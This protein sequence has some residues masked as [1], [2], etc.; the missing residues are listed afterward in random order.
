MG[1]F[2]PQWPSV[3]GDPTRV[4]PQAGY[5]RWKQL[6]RDA[7]Q[8]AEV[9]ATSHDLRLF[10]ASAL[11]SGGASVKQVQTFLGHASAGITLRTYA[12]MFPGDEGRTQTVLDAALSSAAVADSVRTEAALA[13]SV[14]D[15][16]T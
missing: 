3:A 10:A 6:W 4:T 8:A 11:L 16:A 2:P 9:A 7:A 12:H 1:S 14:T 15:D 13:C 5:R